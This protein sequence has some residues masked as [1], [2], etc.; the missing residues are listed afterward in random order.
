MISYLGIGMLFGLSAGFAPGPLLALVIS[1]TLKHGASGGVKVAL[2]P[3]ITDLPIIVLTLLVLDRVAGAESILGGISILGG[4]LVM[5]LGYRNLR[6]A[7]IVSTGTE[8]APESLS[9]GILVNF[10]SPHPYLFWFSVGGPLIYKAASQGLAPPIIFV[11]TFYALLVGSKIL[12]A[13]LV[14]KSR[15]FVTGKAYFLIIR[16]L[17]V[18]L[19][20]FSLVLFRDGLRLLG[21]LA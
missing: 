10:F 17:G 19:V 4:G 9:K 20:G 11:V 13:L 5:Y 16:F 6:A 18:L 15:S 14:A 7:D 1:E 8:E 21:Y 12:L 2:A 3:V